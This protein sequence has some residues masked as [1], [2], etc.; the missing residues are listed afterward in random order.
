M[1]T[2]WKHLLI[3]DESDIRDPIRLYKLINASGRIGYF[4]VAGFAVAGLASLVGALFFIYLAFHNDYREQRLS[5]LAIF[6]VLT[7]LSAIFYVG[8]KVFIKEIKLNPFRLYTLNPENFEF[9]TGELTSSH[10]IAHEN[11]RQ[12]RYHV[13]GT[14][15]TKDGQPLFVLEVFSHSIWGKRPKLP[16]PA[17]FMYDK[18]DPRVA[19]LIGIDDKYIQKKF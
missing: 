1:Y 7:A 16:I 15:A 11:R 3:H 2:S 18:N 6:S 12:G 4:A 14:A 5:F 17:H 13:N 19:T 10:Y 9:V 8:T